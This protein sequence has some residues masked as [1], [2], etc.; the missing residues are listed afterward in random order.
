MLNLT[1]ELIRFD[2]TQIENDAMEC[3]HAYV[4]NMYGDVLTYEHQE[5]GD[6]NRYNLII[7]NT[8]QP[9]VMFA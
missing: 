7:K 6:K 8:E 2:S 5:I 4:K 1:M 9:D 3:I